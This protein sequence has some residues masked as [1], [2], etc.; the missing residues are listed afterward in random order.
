MFE[1]LGPFL[2]SGKRVLHARDRFHGVFA[3]DFVPHSPTAEKFQHS[4]SDSYRNPG[5][6]LKKTG[7]AVPKLH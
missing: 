3:F 5:L 6:Q 1:L 7:A 2:L 4:K